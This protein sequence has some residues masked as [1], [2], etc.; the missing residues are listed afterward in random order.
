MDRMSRFKEF[1]D[2][3]KRIFITT[4]LFSRGINNPRVNLV[5]NYDTPGTSINYL[6]RA[7]RV[8]A[9]D[10]R[11]LVLTFVCGEKDATML[12]EIQDQFDIT[13]SKMDENTISS[14]H[15][16]ETKHEQRKGKTLAPLENEEKLREI[17][18][19]EDMMSRL[20]DDFENTAFL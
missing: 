7:S 11:G 12:T 18:L 15:L 14:R 2:G 6:H 8:M 5:I 19:A 13:I 1:I 20:C 4:N 3:E 9:L 16:D 10:G 17:K